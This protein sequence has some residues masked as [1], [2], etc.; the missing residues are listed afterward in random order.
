MVV[1]IVACATGPMKRSQYSGLLMSNE[2]LW[3]RYLRW[4]SSEIVVANAEGFAMGVP[5]LMVVVAFWGNITEVVSLPAS[6][7]RCENMSTESS[8]MKTILKYGVEVS[9]VWQ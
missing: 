3:E 4:R 6:H 9:I 8:D 1:L 2:C 7:K 5:P